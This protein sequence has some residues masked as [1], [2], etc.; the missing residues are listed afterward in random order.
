MRL[1]RRQLQVAVAFLIAIDLLTT[2]NYVA[3]VGTER[4]FQQG[5]RLVVLLF[6]AYF[7]LQG[8]AWARWVFTILLLMGF[9]VV[10]ASVIRLGGFQRVGVAGGALVLAMC[11]A[12]GIIAWQLLFAKN[13]RAFFHA[14]RD[15][16]ELRHEVGR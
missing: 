12:Y 14:H 11:A 1:G 3:R 9:L 13:V 8:K 10:V 16:G 5:S 4:L 7:L 6:L 2:A 15:T